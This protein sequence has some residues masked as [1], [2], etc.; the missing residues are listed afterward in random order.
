MGHRVMQRVFQCDVCGK[1]PDDGE[2]LWEMCGEHWCEDCCDNDH[3]ADEI[4]LFE[5]TKEQLTSLGSM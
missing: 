3:E 2:Y 1:T 5:G 4:P